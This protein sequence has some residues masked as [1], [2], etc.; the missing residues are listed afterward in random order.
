[1]RGP[2]A[3]PDDGSPWAPWAWAAGL[4]GAAW[5][6]GAG[7]LLPCL[8]VLKGPLAAVPF[9]A[10]ALAT[11]VR[12]GQLRWPASLDRPPV[13]LA[14]AFALLGSA[15]LWYVSGLRV[16]GDEP[17]YLLM[18]QSLWNERDL[19]LRDNFDR[20]D[21]LEYTPGPVA[22][23]YG[24]PRWDGRP[25]PAHSPGLPVLLAPFYAVGGRRACALLLALF[26]AL[27]AGQVRAVAERLGA[28]L[29]SARLAWAA[30]LGPPVFFYGFHLYTE[31]PSA[32]AIAVAVRLLTP[33]AP[34]AS[35]LGAA[36]AIACLPWLHLK[37]L[38]AAAALAALGAARLR[39]R[40]LRGFGLVLAVAGAA[41]LS[42]YH[43]VFGRPSP[44]AIYGG[45]PPEFSEGSPFR[46]LAGLLL[47]RSFGLL[48]FAPVWALALPG[49]VRLTRS[50][51]GRA[52]LAVLG[53]L[54]GPA[55]FWRMWW[56][57]QCPPARF[58]VPAAV[59]LGTA[60]ALAT[61]AAAG[62]GLARWRGLLL[63][64]GFGIALVAI[65]RPGDL[66]LVNRGD[67]PTR[68]W[69][70][71]SG[72]RPIERY[73]PSL[74]FESPAETRVA[75]VWLVALGLLLALDAL[76]RRK[77][78]ADGWFGTPLPAI[79]FCLF[80]GVLVDVWARGP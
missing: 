67:R 80:V 1:M 77:A 7:S 33:R 66:L 76:A 56:G 18:A 24:S 29:P 51:D 2:G 45:M 37:L 53:C 39:G 13:A 23:H 78:R 21:Y 71:L 9:L 54:A 36:A 8:L 69:G 75:I 65:A 20:Q 12:W 55:L 31:L 15:G 25:F 58:L 44:F 64:G 43:Y 63:A 35:A 10:A 41:F 74:V 48:P 40:P 22:P 4:A 32:L 11:L 50:P 19:D 5:V 47:D 46:A 60:L 3:A 70:A 68:L 49:C 57:G 72:E 59:V 26:G 42:W 34:L 61:T 73:L 16:S 62:R 14:V 27:L 38:L 6:P 17:H 79:A 30:V 28:D 52:L